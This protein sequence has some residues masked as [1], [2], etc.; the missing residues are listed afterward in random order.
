VVDPQDR[1][2]SSTDQTE[3]TTDRFSWGLDWSWKSLRLTGALSNTL[4]LDAPLTALDV[5]YEF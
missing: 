5:R 3:S 2:V 1:Y 4:R